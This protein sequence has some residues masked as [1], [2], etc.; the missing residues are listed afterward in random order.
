MKQNQNQNNRGIDEL[1]AVLKKDKQA[2][3]TICRQSHHLFFVTYL[4]HIIEHQ[5]APFHYEMFRLS[6]NQSLK[7]LVVMGFRN[8]AKSTLLTYSLPIWSVLGEHQKKFVVIASQTRQQARMH[9]LNIKREL[10][11][12]TLLK[13]DLGPFQTHEDEWGS[14]TITLPKYGAKIM[15][16]SVEQ[17]VRGIRHGNRRPDLIILDDIEDSSSINTKERRDKTHDWLTG[18]IIP[19]G[20]T[21]TRVVV[22]GN[23]L[24][25]DSLLLRLKHAIEEDKM[26]GVFRAFPLLEKDGNINWLSKFPDNNAVEELRK[27]TGDSRT[28][29]REYLLE[30]VPSDNQVVYREWIRYYET[31]PA[32]DSGDYQGTIIAIDPA[33]SEKPTADYTAMVAVSVFGS[34]KDRKIYVHRQMVNERITPYITAEKA[35]S[36]L[37]TVGS[38]SSTK[39]I[40]EGNSYQVALAEALRMEGLIVEVVHSRFNKRDRLIAASGP[41][42]G[43]RVFFPMSGAEDLINQIIDF[44]EKHD[45]LADAFAMAIQ[46]S[47]ELKAKTVP[48]I[49]IF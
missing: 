36:L 15:S 2:R 43:G 48:E 40:V 47:V 23:L 29:K 20:D 32:F 18:E 33:S 46:G 39:L 3:I 11:S 42:E 16:A 19:A 30:L 45:D 27:S 35:K 24:H 37:N 5:F 41:V 9:L 44:G 21:Y 26:T 10:E 49:Y 1:V 13:Q 38:V 34:E 6:Q 4:G 14:Y 25:E 22:V 31:M 17:S 8:C 7:N 28:W 12:N